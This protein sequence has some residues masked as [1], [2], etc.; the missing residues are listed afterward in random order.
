MESLTAYTRDGSVFPIDT[1]LRPHGRE[2]ELIVTPAQL[3]IYFRD[4]A[5]PWEALTYLKLR[6]IAG[7][8]A[9]SNQVLHIVQDGI[10]VTADKPEF[11]ADL[12]DMRR[13][14]ERSE[15]EQNFKTGPGGS[16]DIDYL[17]GALQAQHGLWRV[18]NLPERLHRL[19]EQ[20]LISLEECEELC[21]NARYLRTVEH[22]VRLVSGRARKWLPVADHPRRAVQKLLWRTLGGSDNFNP[23]MPLAEVMERTRGLYRKYLG[24]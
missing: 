12:A 7:D 8:Q 18:G 17:A 20:K 13:R 16:Y 14:L 23:E 24:T 21:A 5:K 1:R 3:A 6:H 9:L 11:A 19:C 15:P 2:G 22:V 10:S 4:E